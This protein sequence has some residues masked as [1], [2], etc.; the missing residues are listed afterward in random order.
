MNGLAEM[1][2]EKVMTTNILFGVL[3]LQGPECADQNSKIQTELR[4]KLKELSPTFELINVCLDPHNMPWPRPLTDV[5]YYFAPR[6]VNPLFY[7]VGDELYEKFETHYDFALLK[8]GLKDETFRTQLNKEIIEKTEQM[9]EEEDNQEL[10]PT[11]KMLR[12][13]A[14]EMWNT[15]K[16]AGKGLPVLAPADIVE[17]RFTICQT[18]PKLTEEDRCTECGCFMKTKT[19][20]AQSSCPLGKWDKFNKE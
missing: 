15:A 14:K 1:V 13:L 10:P 9:F 7:T 8:S 2:N 4:K 11:S 6:V 17:E 18:C 16:A 3:I 19:Q 12:G 5:L 20:L